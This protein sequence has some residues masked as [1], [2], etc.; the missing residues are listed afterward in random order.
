[1]SPM[2]IVVLIVVIVV[3]IGAIIGTRKTMKGEG[4]GCGSKDCCCETKKCSIR[5]D[6][7][8]K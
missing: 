8:E 7:S 1:M 4:C 3:I 6:D 2:T 5:K